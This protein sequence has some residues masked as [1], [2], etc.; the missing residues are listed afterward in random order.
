[1]FPLKKRDCP[2]LHKLVVTK[3]SVLRGLGGEREEALKWEQGEDEREERT[4][5]ERINIINNKL[6]SLQATTVSTTLLV[7]TQA[8]MC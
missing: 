6:L 2:L 4:G 5:N 1:M 7:Q 3:I 8:Y